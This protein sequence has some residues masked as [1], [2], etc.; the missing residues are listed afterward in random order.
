MVRFEFTR[1]FRHWARRAKQHC[2]LCKALS[3]FVYKPGVLPV[4]EEVAAK[5]EAEGAGRRLRDDEGDG[6]Q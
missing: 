5:A 4:S 3:L 2:V 1:E 6:G